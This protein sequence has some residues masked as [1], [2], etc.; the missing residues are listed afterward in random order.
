MRTL[1][2]AV[3]AASLIAAPAQA[4]VFRDYDP[5]LFLGLQMRGEPIVLF[6]TD[7][8]CD[9]CKPAD[10]NIKAIASSRRFDGVY[11]L[12]IDLR[13]QRRA[14][15]GFGIQSNPT[16]IGFHGFDERQRVANDADVSRVSNV[17]GSALR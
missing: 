2:S 12:K 14:A 1:A 15:K 7:G 4:A 5:W 3:T 10:M 9:L 16:I 8:V 17:F 6:V 13:T 11:V